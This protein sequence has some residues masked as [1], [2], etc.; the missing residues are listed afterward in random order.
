MKIWENKQNEKK[1][2]KLAAAT[3]IMQQYNNA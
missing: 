3:K 1:F 2:P